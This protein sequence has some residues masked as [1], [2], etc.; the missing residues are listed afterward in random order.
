MYICAL[1]Y[2]FSASNFVFWLS[3][4]IS[5]DFSLTVL[6]SSRISSFL[7]LSANVS[8]FALLTELFSVLLSTFDLFKE[9][10][11]L[12]PLK[13]IPPTTMAAI[14]MPAIILNTFFLLSE[15]IFSV[16]LF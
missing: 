13:K 16:S 3:F 14:P 12:L 2:A 15:Y 6:N 1:L 4:N 7:S 9:A 11:A 8:S 10:F 5:S